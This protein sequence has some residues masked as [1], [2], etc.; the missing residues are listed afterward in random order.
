MSEFEKLMK[1][2]GSKR[3]TIQKRNK[4]RKDTRKT[5]LWVLGIPFLFSII[6][7]HLGLIIFIPSLIGVVIYCEREWMG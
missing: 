5:L 3:P 7:P 2:G 4:D 1:S 6:P